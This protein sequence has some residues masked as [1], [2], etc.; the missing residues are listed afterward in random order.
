M[1]KVKRV[2][3][4]TT[5]SVCKP[6]TQATWAL[7][8]WPTWPASLVCKPATFFVTERGLNNTQFTIV[9]I[10]RAFS[11]WESGGRRALE[12][13]NVLEI[14]HKAGALISLSLQQDAHFGA[15]WTPTSM[16][17][18][19]WVTCFVFFIDNLTHFSK[20]R[21]P[22]KHLWKMLKKFL[23]TLRKRTCNLYLGN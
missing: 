14:A 4:T 8:F 5:A 16:Y 9:E 19:A 1:Q 17:L 6:T 11:P 7:L 18:R 2:S 12:I 15:C 13:S 21:P 10:P 3:V 22:K 23:Q 20:S